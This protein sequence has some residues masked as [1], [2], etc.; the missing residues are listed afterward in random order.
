MSDSAKY[1]GTQKRGE[2]F[3]LKEELLVSDIAKKRD[4]VKKVIAA[5][6]V[7]KDVSSLFTDVLNCMMTSNV[8][9][10]KLVYLY[11]MNYAS[12]NPDLCILA[13]SRTKTP[14]S[15]RP[16]RFASPSCTTSAPTWLRCKASSTISRRCSATATPWL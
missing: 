11:I 10:K 2:I 15:A 8:E 12:S 7:G 9:I 14:T 13:A 16:L 4:A 3:E 6:T 5:M 1:F